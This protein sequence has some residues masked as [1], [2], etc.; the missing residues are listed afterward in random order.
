MLYIPFENNSYFYIHLV[1]GL[2]FVLR[3]TL[4]IISA[5][6]ENRFLPAV[7]STVL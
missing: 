6:D 2:S 1:V 4:R 3:E 5:M 7:Q